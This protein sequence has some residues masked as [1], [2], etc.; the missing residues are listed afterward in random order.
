MPDDE[1]DSALR[2]IIASA[3]GRNISALRK[4][5][6]LRRILGLDTVDLIRIVVAAELVY[7]VECDGERLY[8]IDRYG[9]L[10]AAL[11]IGT[12]RKRSAA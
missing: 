11:G 7:G 6:S 4:E 12:E 9:E 5:D 10:L 2:G 1:D 3:T 8:R